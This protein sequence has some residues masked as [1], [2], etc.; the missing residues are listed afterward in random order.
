M[1]DVV[2]RQAPEHLRVKY[3]RL[4]AQ[5][6]ECLSWMVQE[7]GDPAGAMYWVDRAQQWAG[8]GHWPEMT[9]YTHVRRST[10]ARNGA[11]DGPA[12]AENATEALQVPGAP[13]RI[14]A[15]AGKQL[16]YGH[17]LTGQ[18]DKC[19]YALDQVASLFERAS[20]EDGGPDSIIR[21][22]ARATPAWWPAPLAPATST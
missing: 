20:T 15:E 11:G 14:T 5:S 9:A 6:G 2:R 1:L 16:A 17:A 22:R 4:Q 12:A 8:L 18:R 3:V 19:H 21:L 7:S 13:P 10:L